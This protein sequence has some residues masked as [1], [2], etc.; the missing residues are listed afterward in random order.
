M[1]HSKLPPID[2][3][4]PG[5]GLKGWKESRDGDSSSGWA[6]D[7]GLQFPLFLDGLNLGLVYRNLGPSVDGFQLPKSIAAGGS[8]HIGSFGLFSELDF[9]SYRD[10]LIRG[11]VEYNLKRAWFRAGYQSLEIEGDDGIDQISLGGGLRVKGWKLDYAWL[12]NSELGDQ[13]RFALTIGFGLSPEER[14]KAAMELDIAINQQM[15][16]HSMTSL[17]AGRDAL[18]SKN[19]IKAKENFEKSLLWDPENKD[20][21]MGLQLAEKNIKVPQIKYQ[22]V[23]QGE[24]LNH[25]AYTLFRAGKTKEAITLWKSVLV[26]NPDNNDAKLALKKANEK[27]ALTR[28]VPRPE[29]SVKVYELNSMAMASYREGEMD[30][31]VTY[32][33]QALLLEPSNTRIKNNLNRVQNELITR[34]EFQ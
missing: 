31:A 15:K 26:L 24:T 21:Q 28:N 13:H 14:V 1:S 33:K 8:Y 9:A 11:G 4:P 22:K 25:K 18:E 12:P 7:L 3:F 23:D 16:S 20:A 6:A 5:L 32:L 19:Y 29:A 30:K 34:T 27:A 10:T 2:Q 17:N